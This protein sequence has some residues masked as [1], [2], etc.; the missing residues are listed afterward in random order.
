MEEITNLFEKI[1]AL[2]AEPGSDAGALA[3]LEHT[4]TEGYACALALEAEGLR[5]ERRIGEVAARLADDAA[6]ARTD[7]LATLAR[8]K[9]T[10]DGDLT[11]LRGRLSTLRR[12]AH[13][14][15]AA[16]PA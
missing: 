14:V 2:L 16:I 1:D 4:L 12:A 3:R 9:S 5:I 6:A 15:R 13:E 8:R 10:A 7:E 11:L